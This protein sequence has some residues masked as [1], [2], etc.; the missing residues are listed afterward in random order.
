MIGLLSDDL[1]PFV[2]AL[3]YDKKAFMYGREVQKKARHNLCFGDFDQEPDYGSGKGRVISFA[4]LPVLAHIRK[5]L[6]Q[7]FGEK[8]K[9]LQAEANL[10][11]DVTECGI[12]FHGDSERRIVIGIRLGETFPLVY[13]WYYRSHPVGPRIDLTLHHGDIYIMSEKASGFDWKR[14]IIP[15]LRHAAG[16]DKYINVVRK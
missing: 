6:P 3:D 4:R 11:Y 13:Q 10:Y 2:I 7:M 14:K 12:G 15:T 9:D 5:Y 8:A 16:C 1:H